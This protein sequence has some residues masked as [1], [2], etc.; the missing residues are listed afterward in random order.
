M[1]IGLNLKNTNKKIKA[2]YNKL[3][4]KSSGKKQIPTLLKF[5]TILLLLLS[6]NRQSFC[7]D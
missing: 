5:I 4:W 6:K 7:K 3:R 1:R 2:P